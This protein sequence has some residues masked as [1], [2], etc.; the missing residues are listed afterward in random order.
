MVSELRGYRQ[1]RAFKPQSPGPGGPV[2]DMGL[3]PTECEIHGLLVPRQAL[4]HQMQLG[5]AL[6]SAT[7]RTLSPSLGR[8]HERNK[9]S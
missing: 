7:M 8:G 6:A 4:H 1:A 2:M 9:E 5:G 3:E